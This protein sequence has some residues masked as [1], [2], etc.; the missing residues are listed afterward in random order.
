MSVIAISVVINETYY[1]HST[2]DLETRTK[3][4]KTDQTPGRYTH[5]CGLNIPF[6]MCILYNKMKK[7]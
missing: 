2:A 4:A 6:Q 5:V 1:K 3:K 7:L